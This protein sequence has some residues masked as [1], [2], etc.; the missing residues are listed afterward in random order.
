[1]SLSL[2][3]RLLIHP[4]LALYIG[5]FVHRE[6]GRWKFLVSCVS[7]VFPSRDDVD[8]HDGIDSPPVKICHPVKSR[9]GRSRLIQGPASTV[10]NS[11]NSPPFLQHIPIILYSSSI[12]IGLVVQNAF[13]SPLPLHRPG[14]PGNHRTG[15]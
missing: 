15:P 13:Y 11:A 5:D 3:S 4:Y 14:C 8:G 6:D 2:K 12:S 1:M 7:V 9:L 10:A